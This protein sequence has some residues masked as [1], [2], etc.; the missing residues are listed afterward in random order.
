[1]EGGYY[2]STDIGFI[3]MIFY[4]GIIGLLSYIIYNVKLLR[5]IHVRNHSLG[6]FFLFALMV[7]VMVVN[8]KGFVDIFQWAILFYFCEDAMD[9]NNNNNNNKDTYVRV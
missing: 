7:Y 4:F 8:L 1:M 6:M 2:M 5:A 9:N 3:R